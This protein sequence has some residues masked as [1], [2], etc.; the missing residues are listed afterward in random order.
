MTARAQ[1]AQI[2]SLKKT[3]GRSA[4][5]RGRMN[6]M[7][8]TITILDPETGAETYRTISASTLGEALTMAERADAGVRTR[9]YGISPA[10]YT[11]ANVEGIDYNV[12]DGLLV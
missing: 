11:T 2:G 8:Y 5:P 1:R 9:L 10:D 7:H 6:P 4:Q 12:A 3:M